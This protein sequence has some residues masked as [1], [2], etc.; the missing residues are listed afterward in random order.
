MKVLKDGTIQINTDG[1]EEEAH[2][3]AHQLVQ[4]TITKIGGDVKIIERKEPSQHHHHSHGHG[5]THSH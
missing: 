1:F 4:E 5:H 2:L 3:E